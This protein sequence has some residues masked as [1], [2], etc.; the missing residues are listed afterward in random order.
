MCCFEPRLSLAFPRKKL[1]PA[2]AHASYAERRLPLDCISHLRAGGLRLR[3]QLIRMYS[4][5]TI[6]VVSHRQASLATNL[7]ADVKAYCGETL[8]IILTLNV[9]EEPTELPSGIKVIQNSRPK[10]FGANH[11]AAFREAATEYF[12][13]VNP[14][15]RLKM[16]P[17]PA[18]L[19][20]L[21]DR[22]VGVAAP[23]VKSPSGTLED[24]AR[25]FPT[26]TRLAAKLFGRSPRLDYET[27]SA[28]ISP[29]WVA[30]MF[31][32]FRSDTY[33]SMNGFDERYF[34]YYEDV[35]LCARLRL[36]GAKVIVEPAADVVHDARRASHGN[37]RH[38][39]WHARSILRYLLS[40][41][42][43]GL[44]QK[45]FI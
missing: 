38:A 23:L 14:D 11:N 12:C 30:G 42:Y 1:D 16:D 24:S 9:A 17:F 13:V 15:V 19:E 36:S 40:A 2:I 28:R 22:D 39:S 31:M 41:S 37:L 26:V 3:L 8:P 34:L 21:T 44:R 33:R 43:R 27:A 32:L 6:S 25:R 7:I 10:G 29:D 45:R 18:L 20:A 5:I 35:D 4:N